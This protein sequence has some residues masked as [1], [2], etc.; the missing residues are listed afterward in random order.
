LVFIEI[1]AEKQTTVLFRAPY[2]ISII[3][4][5]QAIF[6]SGA[7]KSVYQ[8]MRCFVSTSIPDLMAGGCP[9]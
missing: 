7:K 2:S 4:P 5:K 1:L 9:N 8:R 3:A 6:L